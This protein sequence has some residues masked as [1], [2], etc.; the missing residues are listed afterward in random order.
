MLTKKDDPEYSNKLKNITYKSSGAY[1]KL[2]DEYIDQL[3]GQ[4]MVFQDIHFRGELFLPKET[5]EEIFYQLEPKTSLQ[6]ML[7]ALVDELMK[8][9]Q[10]FRKEQEK[11]DWVMYEIE[12][13]DDEEILDVYMD[14]QEQEGDEDR[15]STR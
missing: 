10:D 8:R 14:V 12:S 3:V 6:N 5:I 13:L 4:G 15:K 11:E 7:H 1:K 2:L 9:I